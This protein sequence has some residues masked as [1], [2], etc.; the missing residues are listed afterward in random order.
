[1]ISTSL[2]DPEWRQQTTQVVKNME[3]VNLVK[4]S[5]KAQP[6]SSNTRFIDTIVDAQSLGIDQILV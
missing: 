6:K 4:N 2:K 3:G 1:M 5:G